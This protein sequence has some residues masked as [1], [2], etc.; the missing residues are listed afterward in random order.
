[1]RDGG[2]IAGGLVLLIAL[3][4][5]VYWW[6][7]AEPKITIA[8]GDDAM[9]GMAPKKKAD[10]PPPTVH[11]ASA[12]ETPVAPVL[13]G[14]RPNPEKPPPQVIIP[15]EFVQYTVK[16]GDS[17]ASIARQF[18][19]SPALANVLIA[20]NPLMSPQNLKP[21]RV[22]QVPKDPN[23]IQGLPVKGGPKPT[24]APAADV[25]GEQTYIVQ[26]GDS[27]SKI[28][29]EFYGDLRLSTL[30]FEA[31]RDQLPSEDALK[32]GQHLRIPPKPQR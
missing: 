3:W 23:N 2:R 30:I 14:S 13:M 10:Q 9:R 6:W 4:I 19:G 28:A 8:Q 1:M 31:N 21:G 7:P 20:A 26:Q 15:P 27:L 5:G 29:K 16:D 12:H 24:P 17:F 32:I 11:D 18:Y 25:P 22:I